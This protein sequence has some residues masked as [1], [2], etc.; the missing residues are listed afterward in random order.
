[1][2]ENNLSRRE[3]PQA[4]AAVLLRDGAPEAQATA[5]SLSFTSGNPAVKL[6]TICPSRR[7]LY[8]GYSPEI[9]DG[10]GGMDFGQ[11]LQKPFTKKFGNQ[12]PRVVRCRHVLAVLTVTLA[13]L[14][15]AVI[16]STVY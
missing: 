6:T 4:T 8:M 11:G 7:V 10:Y 2:S 3:L 9:I 12:G 1:M 16:E 5:W 13:S 15:G 14:C